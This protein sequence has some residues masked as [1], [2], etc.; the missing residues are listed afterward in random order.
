MDDSALSKID[1]ATKRIDELNELLREKRPFA[2]VVET[3]VMTRKRT[4]F[5]KKEHSVVNEATN[6]A[7]DALHNLRAALDH[8]YWRIVSPFAKTTKEERAIQFPFSETAA[9]LDEAIKNRLAHRASPTFAKTLLDLAPHGEP[10]GNKLLYL[11]HHYDSINKHRVP[12]PSADYTGLSSKAVRE[13]VPDF[14]QGFNIEDTT[15]SGCRFQWDLGDVNPATFG[16]LVTPTTCVFERKLSIPVEIVFVM[17]LSLTPT[18]MVPILHQAANVV[19]E[20]IHKIR[21]ASGN[22]SKP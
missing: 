14:P 8:A 19:R 12:I 22:Q 9:R 2:Y 5:A 10:S 4:T 11:V 6:I 21:S 15:V 16:T 18:P 20:T 3:N 7:A 13:Q 1:W 17:G